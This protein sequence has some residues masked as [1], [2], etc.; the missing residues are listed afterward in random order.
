MILEEGSSG[1]SVGG[2]EPGVPMKLASAILCALTLCALGAAQSLEALTRA[3]LEKRTAASRN[4]L[5]RYAEAHPKDQSGALALLV[6]GSAAAEG[7]DYEQAIPLLREAAGRLALIA[8]YPAYYAGLALQKKKDYDR[9]L[10]ELRR[11]ISGSPVSP[12]QARAVVLVA[13]IHLDSGVPERGVRLLREHSKILPQPE[14]LLLLA[15]SLEAAR[16]LAAAARAFQKIYHEYPVSP[17]AEAAAPALGR[18]RRRLG[19]RYPAPAP[20]AL[21]TRVERLIQAGEHLAARRELQEMTVML[22]GAERDRARVWLGKARYV[23]GHDSIA[24]QW[25]R[26]LKVSSAEANAERL[27]YLAA[28]ARRLRRESDVLAALKELD[29]KHPASPWRREALVS[30]GNMYLLANEHAAYVPLYQAC[31]DSFSE[32]PETAYCDWKVAWSHYIRRRSEAGERL[33]AHIRRFPASPHASAALYFLGRLAE[34]AGERAAAR[35]Y[36]AELEHEYPNYFYAIL[37]RERLSSPAVADVAESEE[38]RQFLAKIEFPQRRREHDFEP[39]EATRQR[40]E[41]ARLLLSAGLDEWAEAEL[42]FGARADAKAAVLAMELAK[43]ATRRGEHGKSIR[44]IKALAPGYLSMPIEAAPAAFWRLAFP[45]PY[46]DS[47]ERYARERKLDPFFLA[48]LIRQESEF[49]ARAVS[50]ARAYGLTQLLP[51]TGRQLSRKLGIRRFHTS[52]LYRPEINMNLGTYYLRSLID[53]LEGHVEAALAAYNAGKSRA[54]EW[55][56]W[57]EYREAAEFIETIPFT[58]TRNYV[59]MVLRNADLYR[60]LYGGAGLAQ[61]RRSRQSGRPSGG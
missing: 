56:G 50:R 1:G 19:S 20:E 48:A 27:Y 9:A 16:D 21:F 59:Q 25:L 39:D 23:R 15:Q 46:R 3:F 13:R 24:F 22:R 42:R 40:L 38:V 44:Y 12:L 31:A 57:A 47:V 58:E 55:L 29:K 60:R 17:E 8:D 54:R 37:A 51:S 49:D 35:A 28:S 2:A 53:E 61:Q 11:V 26:S 10:G 43:L 33:R 18:L 45:L 5:L 14:G 30:A 6:A 52:M 36:Y 4:A 7:A 41:R 32:H 34:E